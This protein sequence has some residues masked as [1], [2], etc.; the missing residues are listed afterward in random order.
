MENLRRP[1]DRS[2]EPILKRP[3]LM[4]DPERTPNSSAP[5]IPQRQ[6]QVTSASRFRQNDRDAENNDDSYQPQPLP[7]Q[8]LVAQYKSG[9]A[10]LTFNSKLIINN[11]TRIADENR[12][13]EKAVAAT[14][15][16]N[17]L[18]VKLVFTLCSCL[19]VQLV[20]FLILFLRGCVM[21]LIAD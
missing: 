21:E 11:L 2:K 18:E 10:E 7:F 13:A 9:L 17:I 20:S 6:Q 5:M 3:R 14:I 8:E 4:K 15:C 19:Y 12:A 1:F 16:A